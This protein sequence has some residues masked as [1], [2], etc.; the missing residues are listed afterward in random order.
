MHIE[1]LDES[2]EIIDDLKNAQNQKFTHTV[3]KPKAVLFGPAVSH[4]P[5]S[6]HEF[7][8]ASLSS[9]LPAPRFDATSSSSSL[10]REVPGQLLPFVMQPHSV[11]QSLPQSY[12]SQINDIKQDY[13]TETHKK[14]TLVSDAIPQTSKSKRKTAA[15]V[16]PPKLQKSS[17]RSKIARSSKP[18]DNSFLMK[19]WWFILQQLGHESSL[20]TQVQHSSNSQI[21]I[22]PNPG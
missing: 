19:L 7:D 3:A 13:V 4:C 14:E 18:S 21:H 11:P 20:Y 8:I 5:K 22:A 16:N 9:G 10:Q 12:S 1:N 2:W 6:I 15:D 17:Q